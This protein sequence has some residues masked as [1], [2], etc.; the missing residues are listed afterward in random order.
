VAPTA[1]YLR[2]K[3]VEAWYEAEGIS[4]RRLFWHNRNSWRAFGVLRG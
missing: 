4:E 1:H 3:D 2:R